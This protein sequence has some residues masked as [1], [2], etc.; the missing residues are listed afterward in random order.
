[1]NELAI[2]NQIPAIWENVKAVLNSENVS[3]IATLMGVSGVTIRDFRYVKNFKK[4][5]TKCEEE[6]PNGFQTEEQESIFYDTF[7]ELSDFIKEN[8]NIDGKVF[9]K[10]SNLLI[11]GLK[12]EDILIKEYIKILEKLS[13]L[14]LSALLNLEIVTIQS[15]KYLLNLENKEKYTYEYFIKKLKDKTSYPQ[16]LIIK[17]IENLKVNNLINDFVEE[18]NKTSWK[19]YKITTELGDKIRVL[20]RESEKN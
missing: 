6:F 8:K 9:E 15:N 5:F 14:D 10:I 18:V 12:K 16:E 17:A 2:V 19:D 7:V 13:W 3:A 20:I 1:M 11:E 4:L